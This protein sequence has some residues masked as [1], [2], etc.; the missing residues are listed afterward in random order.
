MANI[1]ETLVEG[2][3]NMKP[4]NQEELQKSRLKMQHTKM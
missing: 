3:Q 2:L 4:Q 1:K